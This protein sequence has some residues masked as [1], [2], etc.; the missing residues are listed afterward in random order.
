MSS[1]RAQASSTRSRSTLS[2]P[3]LVYL[4]PLRETDRSPAQQ[5]SKATPSAGAR[6]QIGM[7]DI[8]SESAADIKPGCRA[9]LLRNSHTRF[10]VALLTV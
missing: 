1:P 6:H 4:S 2:R 10:K 7:A 5:P 3:V 8:T 9:D